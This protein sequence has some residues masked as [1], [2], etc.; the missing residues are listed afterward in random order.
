MSRHSKNNNAGISYL[1]K[2]VPHSVE[3][4]PNKY[5]VHVFCMYVYACVCVD[6]CIY[7]CVS[8]QACMHVYTVHACMHT[9]INFDSKLPDN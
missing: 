9:Y 7:L 1:C 5:F 6:L 3:T 8:E 4:L 2:V